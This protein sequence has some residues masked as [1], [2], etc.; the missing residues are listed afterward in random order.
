MN[1]AGIFVFY[2]VYNNIDAALKN[3]PDSSVFVNFASGKDAVHFAMVAL[4]CKQVLK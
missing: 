1:N 4:K 2:T 3:H